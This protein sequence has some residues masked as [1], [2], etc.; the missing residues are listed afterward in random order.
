[1]TILDTHAW[2]WWVAEPARL[3]KSARRT[4]EGARRIGVPA[5]ACLEVAALARRG[6]ITL[7]QPVLDWMQAALALPRVELLALSP[8]VAVN[9]VTLP[10]SFPGDPADRLIVATALVE[11]GTLVTRDDRIRRSALVPTVWA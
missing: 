10:E 7:D 9:A 5:I 3:G 6:R 2:I 4:L 1:V 11:R 8:A